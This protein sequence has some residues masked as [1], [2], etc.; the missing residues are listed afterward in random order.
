MFNKFFQKNTEKKAG[1]TLVQSLSQFGIAVTV[2]EIIEGYQAV[3]FVCSITNDKSFNSVRALKKNLWLDLEAHSFL[4]DEIADS[5]HK[6]FSVTIEKSPK[7]GVFSFTDAMK[8]YETS[9]ES[10]F[11]VPI[12]ATIRKEVYSLDLGEIGSVAVAG[13]TGSGKSVLFHSIINALLLQNNPED[14]QLVLIDPKRVELT[15]YSDIPYLHYP[16]EVSYDKSADILRKTLLEIDRRIE[17]FAKASVENINEY[18]KLE[19]REKLPQM[20]VLIDEFSDLMHVD[21]NVMESAVGEIAQKAVQTGFNII[22]GTSRPCI[23]VYTQKILNNMD[24]KVVGTLCN[25]IDSKLVIG[26]D[27]ALVLT[28]SGDM[29]VLQKGDS[30]PDR[31]QVC[32]ME[33]G[34]IVDRVN[35]LKLN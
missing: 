4:L 22:I 32:F 31:I 18:R 19:D 21:P 23:D 11:K 24:V 35:K 10:P 1:D 20:V 16:V 8:G 15:L 17:L 25:D 13:S 30:K 5:N 14:L 29:L 9:E 28:D 27:D 33:E 6:R 34:E 3:Q 2:D 7:R 12:G 26:S